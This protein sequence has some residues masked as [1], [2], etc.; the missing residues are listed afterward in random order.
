LPL[1]KERS[2]QT[3]AKQICARPTIQ[4]YERGRAVVAV[5]IRRWCGLYFKA[6][7]IFVS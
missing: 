5:V 7:F 2:N 1:S 6:F 3:A 4:G